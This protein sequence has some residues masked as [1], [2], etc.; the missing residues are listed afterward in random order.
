MLPKE[1]RWRRR[2]SAGQ[3][4]WW[5]R[6]RRGEGDG[7]GVVLLF[8]FVEVPLFGAGEAVDG[9]AGIVFFGA[10]PGEADG[11]AAA[12]GFVVLPEGFVG[13]PE[14][15]FAAGDLFGGPGGDVCAVEVDGAFGAGFGFDGDGGEVSV[16]G[17]DFGD[18][19]DG[20]LFVEF[21]DQAHFCS[22]PVREVGYHENGGMGIAGR[23]QR[24]TWAVRW[25]GR[26]F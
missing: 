7:D 8:D 6:R 14:E 12:D 20:V 17:D 2:K 15:V 21:F 4:F 13:E 23:Q 9:G 1:T 24:G 10:E 22:P 26:C 3:S 25:R 16:A 5:N 19:F 11:D 18:G